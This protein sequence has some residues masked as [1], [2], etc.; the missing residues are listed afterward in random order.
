MFSESRNLKIHFLMDTQRLQD[1]NTRIR[2]RTQ[3]LIG[4]VNP[5]DFEL[6][7]SRILRHSK[8][9]NDVLNF[10]VGEF[11]YTPTDTVIQFRKFKQVGKPYPTKIWDCAPETLVYAKPYR[12]KGLVAK[13]KEWVKW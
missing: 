2:G 1:L 7:I 8:H 13:L 9:K 12:E 11:L 6:K 4:Y 10:R 5:D 3:L